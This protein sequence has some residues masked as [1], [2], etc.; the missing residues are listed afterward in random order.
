[1]SRREEFKQ[2]LKKE[3]ENEGPL[4]IDELEKLYPLNKF[5]SDV[6]AETNRSLK[7]LTNSGAKARLLND[8]SEILKASGWKD[9]LQ[10]Y[11][12]QQLRRYGEYLE[13]RHV[14]ELQFKA[15]TETLLH[16]ELTIPEDVKASLTHKI[17]QSLSDLKKTASSE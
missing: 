7:Y 17:K 16:G 9:K 12:F 11:I 14:A 4:S 10:E 2:A 3:L 13:E 5:L 1:M 6:K 8:L 15:L